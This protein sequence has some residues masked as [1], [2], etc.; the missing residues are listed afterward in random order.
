MSKKKSKKNLTH[1]EEPRQEQISTMPPPKNFFGTK[2]SGL[3]Y[4]SC[5]ILG[6]LF[7]LI[8]S[9]LSSSGVFNLKVLAYI[10]LQLMFVGV[11]AVVA[12]FTKT[13]PF[14]EWNLKK[15]AHYS[16]YIIYGVAI[17]CILF[18][19]TPF[20]NV[21]EFGLKQL[22]YN[23]TGYQNA[24]IGNNPG[25]LIF[26]IFGIALLPAI[27][28][29]LV[30]RGIILKGTMQYG[31]TIAI[32]LSTLCF[33]LY[34][35]SIEQTVYQAVLGVALGLAYITT[36]DIKVNMLMHFLNN[37]I[38]LIYTYCNGTGLPQS[39][40]T[41]EIILAIFLVFV[42]V[43]L[44]WLS[45]MIVKKIGKEKQPLVVQKEEKHY[46]VLLI[47]AIFFVL[48]NWTFN[49]LYGFGIDLTKLVKGA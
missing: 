22:G 12:I 32:V 36:G 26:A 16:S 28:E 43:A 35:G 45:T 39:V 33:T 24:L 4:L 19:F 7:S 21:F 37:A 46:N 29:E 8:L 34:H 47:I 27:L 2:A 30:F 1:T 25:E 48:L 3:A 40:S 18:C 9:P 23:V 10:L 6:F 31:K 49:T 41:G 15:T 42:G 38:V 20:A 14:K 13:E 5:F 17:V 44:V 11:I